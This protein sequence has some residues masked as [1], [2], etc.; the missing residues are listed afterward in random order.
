[1]VFWRSARDIH[2]SLVNPTLE[3]NNYFPEFTT[4]NCLYYVLLSGAS[5]FLGNMSLMLK[6][7]SK[8]KTVLSFYSGTPRFHHPAGMHSM[9]IYGKRDM[10]SLWLC[11]RNDVKILPLMQCLVFLKNGGDR[12]FWLSPQSSGGEN[13]NKNSILVKNTY[14]FTKAN[15]RSKN[16][17]LSILLK[18]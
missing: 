15:K 8:S 17:V 11:W 3:I 9:R 7:V 4:E 10:G 14:Q 16:S 13:F 18:F 6:L 5:S 1:M 12:L 2:S